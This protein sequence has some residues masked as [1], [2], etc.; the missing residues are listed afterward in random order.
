MADVQASRDWG[1]TGHPAGTSGTVVESL[2]NVEVTVDAEYFPT[3]WTH[4]ELEK[5]VK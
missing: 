5:E 4:I 1:R 3:L 2:V